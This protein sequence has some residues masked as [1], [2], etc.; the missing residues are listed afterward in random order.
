VQRKWCILV[1]EP[2]ELIRGLLERWLSEAGHTVVIAASPWAPQG[3]DEGT[4]PDLVVVDVPAPRGA[5]EIIQ[6]IRER[7]ASPILLLS[8]SLRRGA[9]SSSHIARE[10]GVSKVLPK[11]FARGE[12]LSAV[13]ESIDGAC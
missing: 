10:L 3:P 8:A 12:L 11:P 2:D 7:Y 1:V 5:E 13:N 4:E 6:S 9:G